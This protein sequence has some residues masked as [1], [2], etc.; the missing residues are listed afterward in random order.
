MSKDCNEQ[1]NK[2]R[3]IIERVDSS[4][5]LCEVF[6]YVA[7]E[8]YT[9]V[10]K[11]QVENKFYTF[12]SSSEHVDLMCNEINCLNVLGGLKNVAKLKKEYNNNWEV[13][14]LKEYIE[15][16]TLDNCYQ[17][18]KDKEKLKMNLVDLVNKIHSVGVCGLDLKSDN[19]LILSNFKNVA[20]FDFDASEVKN[21]QGYMEH[22]LECIDLL[23]N[24]H[25][26]FMN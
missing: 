4:L 3:E 16:Q 15:G 10:A 26:Q 8:G 18:I 22:D 13:A 6:K 7:Y 20:L 21:S 2:A 14:L 24:Y 12:K 19:I 5:E 9:L 25:L 1:I 17:D 11:V 23:F